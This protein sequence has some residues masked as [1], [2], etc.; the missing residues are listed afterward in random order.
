[1]KGDICLPK[2]LEGARLLDT[3]YGSTGPDLLSEA[4][5][6]IEFPVFTGPTPVGV[7]VGL[8]GSFFHQTNNPSL[9]PSPNPD[10]SGYRPAL[11]P[12]LD[13]FYYT[14]ARK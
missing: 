4:W 14:C 10:S 5:T 6:L 3:H 13:L 1:M 8:L 7:G 2:S 11:Y 12:F 9:S